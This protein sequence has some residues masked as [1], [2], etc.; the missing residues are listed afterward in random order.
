MFLS[1]Q[2]APPRRF[3]STQ[4]Y[5]FHDVFAWSYEEILG[6]DPRI[7]EHEITTYPDTKLVGQKLRPVN[8]W[9]AATIKAE[10]EKLLKAGFIYPV[11]LMQ[12]VSN[13]ILVNKKQGTIRMCMDFHDLNKS[14][15]KDNFPTPF[16]DHIVDECACCEVFSLMDVFLGYNQIH[17]K[18]ED[19]HK[20]SFICPWGRLLIIRCLLA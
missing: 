11:Q 15:L 7:I 18:L 19:Q 16:I 14:C 17:I 12:W 10:V 2:T 4:T 3:K 13:P 8:P 5:E 9:K 6:I 20:T 1:E